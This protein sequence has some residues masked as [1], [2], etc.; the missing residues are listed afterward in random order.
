VFADDFDD[1]GFLEV[2]FS[3]DAAAFPNNAS[4]LNV[5]FIL[6]PLMM[7]ALISFYFK[8]EVMLLPVVQQCLVV[9]RCHI[10]GYW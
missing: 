3:D 8:C 7:K 9:R 5:A 1:D 4:R 10:P 2:A 6:Y